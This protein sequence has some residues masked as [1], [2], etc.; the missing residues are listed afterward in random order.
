MVRKNAENPIDPYAKAADVIALHRHYY[1]R[2]WGFTAAFEAK[3]SSDIAAFLAGFDPTRDLFLTRYENGELLGSITIDG[4]DPK[5]AHLRWFIVSDATR[6]KGLGRELMQ[7]A[8][9]F[10]HALDTPKI[11]LTTFAGLDAAEHLYESFGFEK[12]SET[13][14]DQWQS[15]VVERRYEKLF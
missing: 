3:V 15:G 9:D 5:G 2:E 11:W 12:V 6:G 7:L 4:T 8:V 1:G 10:A 13:D 14:Q